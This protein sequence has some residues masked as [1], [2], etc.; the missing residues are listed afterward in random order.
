MQLDLFMNEQRREKQE[1]LDRAVDDIRRRFGYHSVQRAFMY[2]DKILSSLDAQIPHC[3]SSWIFQ[4]EVSALN[5]NKV[6]VEVIVKFS[7]EGAMMPI[8]FIWEDGTK[9][10]IDKVKSKERCASRKAGGTGIMYT[11]MVDGKEC[12]LYYEFDK[13]FMERKSA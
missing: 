5:D 7:T 9:Y 6:Y 1:K 11:V 2:Q 4:W 13:W 12:H 8:E 3:S 10:L